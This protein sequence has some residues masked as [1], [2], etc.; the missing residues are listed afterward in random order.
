S[1]GMQA[2]IR[3]SEFRN[4]ESVRDRSR[5]SYARGLF[6]GRSTRKDSV[7]L[8]PGQARWRKRAVPSSPCPYNSLRRGTGLRLLDVSVPP[9][10]IHNCCRFCI[11][12][13]SNPNRTTRFQP[14]LPTA[15]KGVTDDQPYSLHPDSHTSDEDVCHP[16]P[17]S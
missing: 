13:L 8:C 14:P 6:P 7:P 11:L 10:T 2:N 3:S 5:L 17:A 12:Y 16:R 15:G 4:G 9:K 1:A